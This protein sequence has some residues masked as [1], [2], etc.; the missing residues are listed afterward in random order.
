MVLK[1]RP[2]GY[3]LAEIEKTLTFER[4]DIGYVRPISEDQRVFYLDPSPFLHTT[5][6][7]VYI[8]KSCP[9]PLKGDLIEVIVSDLDDEVI[10]EDATKG[11]YSRFYKKTIS[12]WKR[13]DP[14]SLAKRKKVLDPPE[15]IG[16]FTLPY[17]AER[18]DL[19]GIGLCS[20]LSYLSCPPLLTDAGGMNTAVFSDLSSW[21]AYRRLMGALPVEFTRPNASYF[22]KISSKDKR[23]FNEK[24]S[25]QISFASI[26]LTR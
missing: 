15:I 14:N 24:I 6:K 18:V 7:E 21:R 17:Q 1:D 13:I 23:L 22:Y 3:Q 20:A 9:P 10:P 12:D 2:W 8:A 25:K 5:K 26:R 19:E 16:Y 11:L 4:I